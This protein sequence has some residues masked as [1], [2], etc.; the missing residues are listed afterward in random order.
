MKFANIKL[1]KLVN[2]KAK[3][4]DEVNFVKSIYDL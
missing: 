3:T 4:L 1:N 2:K